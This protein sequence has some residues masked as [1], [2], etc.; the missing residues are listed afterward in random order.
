MEVNWRNYSLFWSI[1]LAF[2]WMDCRN[3]QQN[4]QFPGIEAEV[5]TSE[6]EW[7]W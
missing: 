1:T 2:A 6:L 5:I 3:V 7:Q 4:S